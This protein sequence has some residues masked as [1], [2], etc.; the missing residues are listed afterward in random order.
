MKKPQITIKLEFI[1][2]VNIKMFEKSFL[3]TTFFRNCKANVIRIRKTQNTIILDFYDIKNKRQILNYQKFL[4][5]LTDCVNCMADMYE[6]ELSLLRRLT[7][8]MQDKKGM[9][10]KFH[11]LSE[12]YKN[13]TDYDQKNVFR[14]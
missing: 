9:H 8:L 4:L 13:F 3:S 11:N 10:E 2:N 12:N 1:D 5:Q 6:K 14:A 7:S